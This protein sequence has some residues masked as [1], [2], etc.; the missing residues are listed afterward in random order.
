MRRIEMKTKFLIPFTFLFLLF[1]SCTSIDAYFDGKKKTLNKVNV[2]FHIPTSSTITELKSLL[3]ENNIVGDTAAF[4]S[5][6]DYKE[7]TNN[8]IGAGKYNIEP[9]TSYRTLINGFTKNSLGNGNQEVE[10]KVTFNNCRDIYDLAGKVADNIEMDSI[11]FVDYIL[12]DSVLKK[13]GFN[14]ER[15]IA[16]FLPNTYRFYWDTEVGS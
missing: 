3:L 1:N 4:Q 2:D 12:S 11:E 6:L 15:I 5:V 8:K 13:Y 9:H 14:K 7:F 16:L 10:V